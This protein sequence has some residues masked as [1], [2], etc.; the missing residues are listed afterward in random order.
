LL[1]CQAFFVKSQVFASFPKENLWK[2][3]AKPYYYNNLNTHIL[4]IQAAF[5]IEKNAEKP[6]LSVFLIV[7]LSFCLYL[8]FIFSCRKDKEKIQTK[9]K[10]FQSKTSKNLKQK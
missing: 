6:F 3:F 10:V 8:F 1:G 9:D 5:L 4:S 2:N 7:V